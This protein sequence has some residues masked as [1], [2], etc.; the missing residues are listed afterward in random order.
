MQHISRSRPNGGEMVNRNAEHTSTLDRLYV[1]LYLKTILFIYLSCIYAI[2]L[3]YIFINNIAT[4]LPNIVFRC[5]FSFSISL[6]Y[7]HFRIIKKI[8]LIFNDLNKD[9]TLFACKCY[10]SMT[11]FNHR[12][13]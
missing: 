10:L 5:K 7:F 9:I 8:T 1:I 12:K 6:C 13:F 4:V 11:Y 2:H 3:L